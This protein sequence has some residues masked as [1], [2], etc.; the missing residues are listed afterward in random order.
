LVGHIS[1]SSLITTLWRYGAGQ[2]FLRHFSV[3][4][5][6]GFFGWSEN[7]WLDAGVQ[8]DSIT[9]AETSQQQLCVAQLIL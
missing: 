5:F 1:G 2:L 9:K 3:L 8:Q 4:K 7:R 6:L